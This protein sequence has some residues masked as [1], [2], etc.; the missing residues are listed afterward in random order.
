MVNGVSCVRLNKGVSLN[1]LLNK[2]RATHKTISL[3]LGIDQ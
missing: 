2:T 1:V 3:L